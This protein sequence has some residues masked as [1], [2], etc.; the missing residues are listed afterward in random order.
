MKIIN[1]ISDKLGDDLK[2]TIK[3][4][5]RLS[6]AA[7]TFS[8]YAFEELKEQ[9]EGLEE[10]RFIFSSPTFLEEKPKKRSVSFIFLSLI[11]KKHFMAAS[12][13][14]VC[15]TISVNERFR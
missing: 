10:L 7:A 14:S 11:A 8:V 5:D 1:N 9:L 15:A 2:A 13:K 6:I 12:L 4:G 3:R